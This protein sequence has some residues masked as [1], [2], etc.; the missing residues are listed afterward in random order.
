MLLTSGYESRGCSAPI[1]KSTNITERQ[2]DDYVRKG[3]AGD[4]RAFRGDVEINPV[5]GVPL[6]SRRARVTSLT[7][8]AGHGGP[9]HL[10]GPDRATAG[11]LS[12]FLK[13][14]YVGAGGAT[15]TSATQGTFFASVRLNFSAHG[16]G[17]ACMS[18]TGTTTLGQ[19]EAQGS[20][21]ILG[22][23]GAAA[24]LHAVGTFRAVNRDP[25]SSTYLAGIFANP[26]L[27][28]RRS[29]PTGC[30]YPNLGPPQ[31]GGKV[32]ASFTGFAVSVGAPGASAAP[33]PDG[34]TITGGNCH[35]TG[36]LYGVFQYAGPSGAQFHAY[37]GSGGGGSQEHLQAVSQGT[38]AVLLFTA[39]PSDHYQ[40]KIYIEPTGASVLTGTTQFY[41]TVQISC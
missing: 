34:G 37:T 19:Q 5:T 4:L 39:P 16:A 35:S 20:F 6:K 26:S 1:V 28:S 40:A 18:V 38:N 9:F 3:Q 14:R 27:G 25:H 30:G 11:R 8:Y 21:K 7:Y 36:D 24:R 32:T 41:P 22:G 12:E 29:M 33:T 15:L 17:S 23:T 2:A 31:S 10:N 13:G